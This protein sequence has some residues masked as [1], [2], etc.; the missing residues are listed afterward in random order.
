MPSHLWS[1]PIDAQRFL[2]LYDPS[3]EEEIFSYA[4]SKKPIIL[5]KAKKPL[6]VILA[7]KEEFKDRSISKIAAWFKSAINSN[8]SEVEIIPGASHGFT[9]F[10]KDI[11]K[12]INNWLKSNNLK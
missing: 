4:S 1:V 3:S 6:L 2:S 7:G 5:Q 9:G 8:K 10:D 12:L 11:N